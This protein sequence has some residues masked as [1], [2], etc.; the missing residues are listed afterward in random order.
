V[1]LKAGENVKLKFLKSKV[2]ARAT[3][4]STEEGKK[5]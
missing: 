5:S 3:E 4:M 1:I 2:A